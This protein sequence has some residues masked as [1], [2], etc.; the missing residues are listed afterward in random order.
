MHSWIFC[1]SSS[2]SARRG[3][4]G[5]VRTFSP[6]WIASLV[7]APVPMKPSVE[8][9]APRD[10]RYAQSMRRQQ[11]L[12]AAI[13]MNEGILQREGIEPA[14]RVDVPG[15]LLALGRESALRHVLLDD[16][17]V[18]M[19]LQSFNHAFTVK[20]LHSMRRDHRDRLAL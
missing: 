11:I 4:I 14:I 9:D 3:G 2:P 15:D 7:F 17:D 13:V 10:R 1:N 12:V 18:L 16:N 19:S 8:A 5:S 20:G 6:P